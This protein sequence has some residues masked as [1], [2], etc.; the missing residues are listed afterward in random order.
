M[1]RAVPRHLQRHLGAVAIGGDIAHA[2]RQI[3]VQG[4]LHRAHRGFDAVH[5]VVD[6]SQ[7]VQ[8]THQADGAVAAHAQVA[9]VVEKDHAGTGIPGLW[10]A[11]QGPDQHVAAPGLE[12]AGAAPVIVLAAQGLQALGHGATAQLGKAVDHQASGFTCGV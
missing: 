7:V 8:R 6:A 1:H 9:A 4:G 10:L 3:V 2:H 5:A 12:D 11:E